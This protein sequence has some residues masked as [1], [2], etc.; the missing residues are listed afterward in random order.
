MQVNVKKRGL[1][2]TK[3]DTTEQ[4]AIDRA[5]KIENIEKNLKNKKII[6]KIFV[7]NKIVNFI[8]T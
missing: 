8:T 3:K 2:S 4:E 1:F 7:K 5:K 6:K